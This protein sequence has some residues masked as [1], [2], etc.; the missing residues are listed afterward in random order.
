MRFLYYRVL[1]FFQT[2]EGFA[3][4]SLRGRFRVLY[5]DGQRS[6][7]MNFAHAKNY[8]ELFGGRII[9]FD[10]RAE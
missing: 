5:P 1:D 7:R 9:F 2:S 10:E 8:R 3:G 4:Q 6:Q